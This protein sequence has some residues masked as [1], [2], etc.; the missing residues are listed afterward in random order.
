MTSVEVFLGDCAQE[1]PKQVEAGSVDLVYLD[2]PFFTQRKHTLATRAGD[3]KFSFDDLWG[4]YNDYMSFMFER[5]SRCFEALSDTGS[6]FVHCDKN[7]THFLRFVCDTI[8]GSDRFKSEI[9]WSYK[10]WSNSANGLLPAHQ[11]ILYYTKSDKFTF[12]KKFVSYSE[13]TNIDQIL[14]KR[15][16]DERNKSVYAKGADGRSI[17]AGE[18]KGVPLSDV[19][20]IPYL[21]PKAKERVGYP[22][23]KPVLLLERII[24]LASNE[25]DTVLDPFCGSG[26]TLVAAKLHKRKSIGIDVNSDAIDLALQ[27]TAAPQKTDSNLLKKGRAAYATA[28]SRLAHVLA[29]VSH[30]SV[31]RNAGIDA[32]LTEKKNGD[33]VFVRLQKANEPAKEGIEKLIKASTKKGGG[34]MLFIAFEAFGVDDFS[35]TEGLTVVQSASLQVAKLLED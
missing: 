19:W 31:P 15:T 3:Q 9:I 12:N 22:T 11:T 21:N 29:G 27:R 20:E 17:V 2:P 16:R 28:D 10:R 4:D 5:I 33:F 35:A 8:F 25:G 30:T 32:I 34:Y 1:I 14:Q 26:T 23:Q 13:S 6:L 7:S 18:K 24:E